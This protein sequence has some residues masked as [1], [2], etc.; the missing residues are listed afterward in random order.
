MRKIYG[1]NDL[2]KFDEMINTILHKIYFNDY[3]LLFNFL[4]IARSTVPNERVFT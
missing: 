2:T 1:L 4:P 3:G